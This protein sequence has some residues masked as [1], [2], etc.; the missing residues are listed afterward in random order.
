[1]GYRFNRLDEAVFVTVS[2]PVQTEFG[3]HHRLESCDG[4]L[5]KQKRIHISNFISG[6]IEPK[7]Y[8]VPEL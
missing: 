7:S 4:L 3:I 5:L 6:K 2:N 8:F 1:M